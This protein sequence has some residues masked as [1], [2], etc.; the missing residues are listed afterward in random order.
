MLDLWIVGLCVALVGVCLVLFGMQHSPR[1][2]ARLPYFLR[3]TDRL[4][5]LL[6]LLQQYRGMSVAQLSGSHAFAASL[7]EIEQKVTGQFVLLI[8]DLDE[9]HEQL[10]P[11]LQIH[12]V[13]VLRHH[14]MSMAQDWGGCRRARL[15]SC[16]LNT[17]N[18]YYSG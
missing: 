11:S 13:K 16:R 5:A 6:A 1:Q 15:F 18:S 8:Q 10:F 3:L 12:E 7:K 17:L 4:L 14:W 9:E 2:A